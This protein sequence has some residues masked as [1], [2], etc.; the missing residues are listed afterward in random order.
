MNLGFPAP[1]Q[2]KLGTFLLKY[3]TTGLLYHESPEMSSD[4]INNSGRLIWSMDGS[5]NNSISGVSDSYFS[6]S[7]VMA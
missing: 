6:V 1:S 7:G 5:V 2:N 3:S 4:G